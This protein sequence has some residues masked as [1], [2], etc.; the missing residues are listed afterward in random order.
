MTY[1]ALPAA[2]VF[3]RIKS[4]ESPLAIAVRH[5]LGLGS[6]RPLRVGVDGRSAA[7]KTTFSDNLST[8]LRDAGRTVLRAEIDDFHPPGHGPRSAAG[9]YTIESY[10]A[11]GYDYTAFRDYLLAP[12]EPNGDRRCR[13][14][15]HDS[16]RDTPIDSPAVEVPI[17]AIVIIDGCF[18]LRPE[19]R[20]FWEF[21]IW[22]DVSFETMVER[23]VKRDSAWMPSEDA[24]RTRCRQRW[25]PL[26]TL[27]EQT[28]ARSYADMI[29][30]NDDLAAPRCINTSG[31][32]RR[33]R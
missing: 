17:D 24:V 10:Y 6:D 20:G 33:A 9:G 16:Y 28:G 14:R 19:L 21:V 7:G 3:V 2:T 32:I 30:D 22:L 23:A 18:L 27:Y 13:L 4:M 29:I 1:I 15:L 12:F 26:H 31:R 8:Q 11:A 5:V 25:I